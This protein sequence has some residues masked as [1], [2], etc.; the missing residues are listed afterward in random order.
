MSDWAME[1]FAKYEGDTRRLTNV[2]IMFAKESTM[3]PL[4]EKVQ[5]EYM[6]VNYM[7]V[8]LS[9]EYRKERAVVPQ[10]YLITITSISQGPFPGYIMFHGCAMFCSVILSILSIWLISTFIKTQQSAIKQESC[11][12]F[13]SALLVLRLSEI[14]DRFTPKNSASG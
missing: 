5:S 1:I 6:K 4:A 12:L 9:S 11:A 2:F 3:E 8:S 13:W 10:Q 14:Y 7:H